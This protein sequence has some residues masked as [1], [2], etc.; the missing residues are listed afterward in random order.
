MSKPKLILIGGGGHC[1]SCI[2]VVELENKF[3]IVGIIDMPNKQGQLVSGYEIIGSD[4]DIERL[5]KVGY[6]FLITIGQIKSSDKRELAYHNLIEAKAKIATVVSPRAYISKNSALGLGS[7]VMHNAIV[8]TGAIVGDN[9]IINSGS[10]IEHDATI[11]NHSHI[12]TGAI[13][14]GDSEIG[15]ET[16]I[17]SHATI[18]SQIKVGD[19]VVVGAGSL[20]IK[21][22]ENGSTVVGVPTKLMENETK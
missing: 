18:S 1:K 16:F 5:I 15:S 6:W 17:G 9:C 4:A 11:G 13:V 2:D 3:Q 12:S 8:N 20:V 7:I 19:K 14:N 21:N 22:I 10:I